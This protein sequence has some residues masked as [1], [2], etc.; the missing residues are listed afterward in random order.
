MSRQRN[1]HYMLNWVMKLSGSNYGRGLGEIVN[2]I[3]TYVGASS[4]TKLLFRVA[5]PHSESTMHIVSL[6]LSTL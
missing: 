3:L 1:P 5:K 6:K 4:T 2:L